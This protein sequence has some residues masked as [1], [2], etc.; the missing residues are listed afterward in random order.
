MTRPKENDY[1][2]FND[3]VRAIS[4]TN[5]FQAKRIRKFIGEQ[6]ESYW[7]FAES[8]TRVAD[9]LLANANG[10]LN[11]AVSAYTTLC[12]RML[13]DQIA[14]RKSGRYTA[15]NA[16]AV[17]EAV[18]DN[19]VEMRAYILGLLMTYIFWPNHYAL[20]T[21]FQDH[22]NN[23]PINHCLEIGAGHGLFSASLLKRHPAASLD[24]IDISAASIK[25]G[26]ELMEAFESPMA[27]IQ[28]VHGDFLKSTLD[29]RYD[30]I[31]MGEI[32]EH[33]NEPVHFLDKARD[34]LA[35]GGAIFM[36]TCANCPAVDHV[37]QFHNVDH[38][39]DVITEAG[40]VTGNE[41][42]LAAEDVPEKDWDRELVTINYGVILTAALGS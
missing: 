13:S 2:K 34:L 32:L 35:H 18:Y 12:T 6:D 42:A 16:A 33:V 20:F 8:V 9:Q 37:Y 40:L 5:P 29:A 19:P 17:K 38:I 3:L 30:F 1:P 24:V 36:T 25:L 22:I 4:A 10:S 23:Q 27:H 26:S 15:D 31:I 39:R 11:D 41:I 14:F 21:M 7:A 28:F